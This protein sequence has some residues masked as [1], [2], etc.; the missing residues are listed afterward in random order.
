MHLPVRGSEEGVNVVRN[1]LLLCALACT[2]SALADKFD[3]VIEPKKSIE[4]RAASEGLIE[5]VWVERGDMVD[6]GQVLVTLDSGVE[7]AAVEAAHYR[8]T[9]EGKIRSAKSRVAF[10]AAKFKRRA[11]LADQSFLS[12]HEKD[13]ALT[14]K[15]LAEAE[16]IEAQDD[17]RLAELEYQRLSEQLRLRTIQSPIAGVVVDRMLNPGEL[18]DNRDLRK[19]ILKLAEIETLYVES[20]LPINVYGQVKIGQSVDILPEL[21]VGGSYKAVIR[22]IDRVLDAASGTFGVRLELPNPDLAIPAGLKCLITLPR[23]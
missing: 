3:C 19:P 11:Q 20:L 6:V 12:E 5:K 14:E 17:R 8:A 4:I 23:Q 21:A 7:Q 9:M 15:Q 16:L 13:E 1:C 22:V 10:T 18:A 2:K